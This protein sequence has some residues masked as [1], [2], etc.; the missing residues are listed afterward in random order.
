MTT[1]RSTKY[2]IAVKEY[3]TVAGHATNNDILEDLRQ[4][5]KDLSATTIHRITARLLDRGEISL[6][7]A[8]NDNSMRF[9]ANIMPHDHF[10]CTECGSLRDA[11]IK[12]KIQPILE[13]AIGGG[14]NISGRLTISGLCNKCSI[15]KGEIYE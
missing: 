14:C 12:S 2:V 1:K 8:A 4:K 15:I 11:N 9:D 5:Y 7:P 13:A 10:K 6:A 3:L